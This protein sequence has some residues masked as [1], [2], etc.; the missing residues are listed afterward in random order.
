MEIEIK[1]FPDT[2]VRGIL[3]FVTPAL[4]NLIF[5]YCIVLSEPNSITCQR[6]WIHLKLLYKPPNCSLKNRRVSRP[7]QILLRTALSNRH[8][9]ESS[10]C[11]VREAI[12][13]VVYYLCQIAAQWVCL[14]TLFN[15]LSKTQ[16]TKLDQNI[17]EKFYP[18]VVGEP[19][20][21]VKKEGLN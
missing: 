3:Y 21:K 20:V 18:L 10:E 17:N 16:Q 11:I 5:L 6:L 12:P 2:L 7:I 15:F 4:F 13:Y 1:Y 19:S 14:N 8:P 9:R